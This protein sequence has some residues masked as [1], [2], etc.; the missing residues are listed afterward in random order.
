MSEYLV[1]I[2][3]SHHNKNMKDPEQILNFDFVIMKASEGISFKD[4]M[5][6]QYNKIIDNSGRMTGP[7]KGAYHYA[8]PECGN[9]PEMEAAAFLYQASNY[10]NGNMF[11]A[12]DVEGAALRVPDLDDW[13]LRWCKYIHEKTGLHPLIYTSSAY[14]ELFPKCAKWGAGLWVAKWGNKPKKSDIKP[15]TFWA[16]WQYTSRG[17]VSAVQTDFNYFN[18]TFEQLYK[19]CE[20]TNEKS[21][22]DS[23]T[24]TARD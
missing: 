23:T 17:V 2:D 7:V 13:C 19:Y 12:L 4:S 20:V 8:R 15:W 11:V 21:A 1:G 10:L 22:D 9:M 5:F 16:L 3:I 14:T 6:R 24:Y 18:G